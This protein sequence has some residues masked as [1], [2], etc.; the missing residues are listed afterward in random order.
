MDKNKQIQIINSFCGKDEHGYINGHCIVL[1]E[2]W[3]K[4][5]TQET[6]EE[7]VIDSAEINV[8]I[9]GGHVFVNLTFKNNKD[10]DLI[11]LHNSINTFIKKYQLSKEFLPVISVIL[12]RNNPMDPMQSNSYCV[13]WNPIGMGLYASD[14]ESYPN[15]FQFTFDEENFIFYE[16][17]EDD[18]YNLFNDEKIDENDDEVFDDDDFDDDDSFGY[19]DEDY[20]DESFDNGGV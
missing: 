14:T 11:F 15:E 13:G 10:I 4:D 18:E 3:K 16:L 6:I 8:A 19:I 1:E 2:L 12:Q 20:T 9:T 5:E 7:I 17:E